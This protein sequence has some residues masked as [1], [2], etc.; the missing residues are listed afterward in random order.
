M[1]RQRNTR[2]AVQSSDRF[3]GTSVHAP[4]NAQADQGAARKAAALGEFL[5]FAGDFAAEQIQVKQGK[6]AAEG[7]TAAMNGEFTDEEL[8][9]MEKSA[10]FVQGA[11]K[12]L[13]KQR[14]IED[15]AAAD[16]WYQTEFDKGAGLDELRSGLN[17][18]W[19]GRY[20]GVSTGIAREIAPLMAQTSDNIMASHAKF[21]AAT[22]H[23]QL[24]EA[25]G[26]VLDQMFEAG[27]YDQ[28]SKIREEGNGVIG[29]DEFNRVAVDAINR[30]AL[31]SLDEK[32]WDLP[33]FAKLKENKKFSE[34]IGKG[35]NNARIARHKAAET[36]TI[37]QQGE[38]LARLGMAADAGDPNFPDWMA[39]ATT[40]QDSGVHLVESDDAAKALWARWYTANS[41]PSDESLNASLWAEG[42]GRH[43]KDDAGRDTAAMQDASAH[44]E[45]IADKNPALQEEDVKA[46]ARAYLIERSTTNNYL[47]KQLKGELEISPTHPRFVD[48][49]E[50]YK[51]F[52][53]ERKGWVGHEIDPRVTRSFGAY[54][55]H[56]RETG[57][58]KKAIE[59]ISAFD[60]GLYEAIKPEDR[61]KA[62]DKIVDTLRD[63]F[64]FGDNDIN[65][66]HRLRSIVTEDFRYYVESGMPYEMA[67]EESYNNLSDRYSVVDGE[68]YDINDG[69]G[70]DAQKAANMAKEAL[71]I[72]YEET[73]FWTGRPDISD[74]SIIPTPGKQGYVRV[75]LAGALQSLGSMTDV[76]IADL[77]ANYNDAE[78]AINILSAKASEDEKSAD[79][80]ER[81]KAELTPIP[82]QFSYKHP[83]L[84]QQL[85]EQRETKWNSLTQAQRDAHEARQRN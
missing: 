62:E 8:H 70:K 41:K 77:M 30:H 12:V 73:T 49:Y 81:A 5:G 54:A 7:A 56:L 21:Q 17:E 76:P 3:V 82:V 84:Y 61:T 25:Q 35:I 65:D 40:K 10:A 24:V 44:A 46:I 75:A 66:S 50:L 37:N 16:H 38:E 55:R 9:T 27:N 11:Q 29:K 79:V 51:T 60:R 4:S 71:A 32:V 85:L 68:L 59:R 63:G 58:T 2:V 28:W 1:A 57:D 26:Q 45:S 22:T 39:R 42:S 20:D 18:F 72:D 67:I 19:K 78:E 64:M 53:G 83:E 13:A 36:A 43:I 23:E 80:I 31:E 15:A 34:T 14:I 47:P 69:W 48:A 74:I 33:Q 6:D 52:E